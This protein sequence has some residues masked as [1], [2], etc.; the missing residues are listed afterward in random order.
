MQTD[1]FEESFLRFIPGVGSA[2]V[3]RLYYYGRRIG[4]IA[5]VKIRFGAK[6]LQVQELLT[7]LGRNIGLEP[8]IFCDLDLEKLVAVRKK[9]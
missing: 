1:A 6:N 9:L 5:S 4:N 7:A 8:R 3:K 2:Y